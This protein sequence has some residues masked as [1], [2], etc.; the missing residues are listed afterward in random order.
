MLKNDNP[1]PMG[2]SDGTAP[3]PLVF[4]PKGFLVVILQDVDETLQAKETL[5]RNGFDEQDLRIYSSQQILEDH[6][7][8]LAQQSAP[9]RA[10]RTVTTDPETPA[11]YF[12]YAADGHS[13]LWA[14]LAERDLAS[15]AIRLLVDH[16]TLY[17]RY[18]DE[19]G[20][21]EDIHIHEDEEA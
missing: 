17:V 14:R 5:M 9:R 13:A 1:W 21:Y 11:L 6:A 3:T 18:Y 4:A 19:H 20:A 8:Y 10:I 7:T 15:R 12:G 16:H 2:E